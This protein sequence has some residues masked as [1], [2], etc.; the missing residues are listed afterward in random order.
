MLNKNSAQWWSLSCITLS[1][2]FLYILW[3]QGSLASTKTGT[4]HNGMYCHYY[5]NR[6]CLGIKILDWFF[7][8]LSFQGVQHCLSLLHF[9]TTWLVLK[10]ILCMQYPRP[11]SKWSYCGSYYS[12]FL[13]TL[14]TNN[15]LLCH[16]KHVTHVMY[17]VQ[18]EPLNI[19]TDLNLDQAI[20]NTFQKTA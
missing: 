2:L 4:E 20:W 13:Q 10:V 1:L 17:V 7:T 6:W 3:L 8:L 14:C 19:A 11:A 12:S 9:L 18:S 15:V 5:L 16:Q